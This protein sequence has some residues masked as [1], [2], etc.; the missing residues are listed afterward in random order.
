MEEDEA[1][2]DWLVQPLVEVEGDGIRQAQRADTFG[3]GKR[4]Q[5]SIFE[6]GRTGR[7]SSE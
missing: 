7:S 5:A 2:V 6:L 1:A 3:R 4:S